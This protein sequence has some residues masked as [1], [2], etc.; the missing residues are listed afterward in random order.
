MNVEYRW[1]KAINNRANGTIVYLNTDFS[2]RE[3]VA[4]KVMGKFILR[5]KSR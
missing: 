2:F 5:Y 4:P 3:R 1:N